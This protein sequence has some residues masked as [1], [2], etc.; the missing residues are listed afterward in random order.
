VDR[1]R[2][3]RCQEIGAV[4][5][6]DETARPQTVEKETNPGFHDLI[7]HFYSMTGVPVVLNTSFNVAG[8]PIVNTP[9]DALRCFHASGLEVLVIGN[10]IL[11][12]PCLSGKIV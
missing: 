2:P 3:E 12:K 7:T 10:F 4:V 5:H 8:E 11:E 6:V 9:L 1:V